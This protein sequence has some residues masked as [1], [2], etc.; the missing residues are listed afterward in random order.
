MSRY[1]K[2]SVEGPQYLHDCAECRFLGR[3]GDLDVYVCME[4]QPHSESVVVRYGYEPHEYSSMPVEVLQQHHTTM[5][6]TSN[7]RRA[8]K[9]FFVDGKPV[10]Q[11][12]RCECGAAYIGCG[13]GQIGHSRWCPWKA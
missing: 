9:Y 13:R 10:T 8:Y 12:A 4:G 11:Q 1:T 3:Y 5:G 7:L 6:P 2:L